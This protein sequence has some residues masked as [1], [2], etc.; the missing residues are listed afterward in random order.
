MTADRQQE[1]LPPLH[2]LFASFLLLLVSLTNQ[3]S[4]IRKRL[5]LITKVSRNSLISSSALNRQHKRTFSLPLEL[6]P[7]P[8]GAFPQKEP[9]F[10]SFILIKV[11]QKTKKKEKIEEN[12]CHLTRTEWEGLKNITDPWPF[13]RDQGGID[14]SIISVSLS[15]SLSCTHFMKCLWSVAAVPA[16]EAS[17]CAMSAAMVELGFSL[18]PNMWGG[19]RLKTEPGR[20]LT[21]GR[22]QTNS[23]TWDTR[24]H[25]FS[26]IWLF[27]I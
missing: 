1:L 5:L 6:L 11:Y 24:S 10:F 13:L 26:L 16:G 7:A 4:C 23:D 12:L 21:C 14:L 22:R 19:A 27:I 17:D 3:M 9:I 20:A 2:S 18:L 25:I 8:G 15:L